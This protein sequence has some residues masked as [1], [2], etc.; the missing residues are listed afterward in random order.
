MKTPIRAIT[1]LLTAG[2][3]A[4]G[5][6]GCSGNDENK[7]QENSAPSSAETTA[8]TTDNTATDEATNDEF[9]KGYVECD[10]EKMTPTDWMSM[11]LNNPLSMDNYIGKEIT[12]ESDFM[13]ISSTSPYYYTSYEASKNTK[14]IPPQYKPSIGMMTLSGGIEVDIPEADQAM[15]SG[16]KQGDKVKVTG[17]ISGISGGTTY[18]FSTG[19]EYAGPITIEKIS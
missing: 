19:T 12:V 16:L 10:G 18:L 17:T 11:L 13:M 5:L 6:V 14:D 8:E 15:V 9:E 4:F 2:V 1:A 3:L 7:A